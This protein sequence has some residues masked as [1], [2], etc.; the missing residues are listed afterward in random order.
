MNKRGNRN[1]YY[2]RFGK[3]NFLCLFKHKIKVHMDTGKTVYSYCLR[4]DRRM[5]EQFGDGYQ[6]VDVE[7]LTENRIGDIIL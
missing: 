6:P 7:F 2:K 3:F 5:I 1:F 4:C